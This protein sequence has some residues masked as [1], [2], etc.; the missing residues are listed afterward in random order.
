M[1]NAD[2]AQ[3][4]GKALPTPPGIN[5]NSGRFV[6]WPGVPALGNKVANAQV[7]AGQNIED[8]R[9]KG[10][11]SV[12]NLG[13]GKASTAMKGFGAAALDATRTAITDAATDQQ[14]RA[15]TVG[16]AMSAVGAGAGWAK[17][18]FETERA[19]EQAAPSM[20]SAFSKLDRQFGIT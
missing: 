10:L 12:I 18:Y 6:A 17:D 1:I 13:Q 8:N 4:M 11:Q 7:T 15:A 14:D 2:V 20:Q 9:A 3:K 5:P 16:T 19:L